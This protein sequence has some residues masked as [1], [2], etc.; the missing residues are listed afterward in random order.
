MSMTNEPATWPRVEATLADDGSAQVSIGG[1][2]TPIQAPSIDEARAQIVSLLAERAPRPRHR[3]AGRFVLDECNLRPQAVN[4]AVSTGG[5]ALCR[6]LPRDVHIGLR[7]ATHRSE[8]ITPELLVKLLLARHAF[9]A[10]GERCSCVGGVWL[11]YRRREALAFDRRHHTTLV[12][13]LRLDVLNLFAGCCYTHSGRVGTH[14]KGR[15][16]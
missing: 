11:A 4:P 14:S 1:A 9:P 3:R 10:L 8:E 6:V 12:A 15:Q 7:D 2:V 5:A 13:D 16:L